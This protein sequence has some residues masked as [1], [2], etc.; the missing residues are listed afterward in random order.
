L[1][2]DLLREK[3]G[4]GNFFRYS[5]VYLFGVGCE[6]G[7][8]TQLDVWP[9]HKFVSI[10]P[11]SAKSVSE[12]V[13]DRRITLLA[14]P[15]TGARC[16]GEVVLS[17]WNAFNELVRCVFTYA[18]RS[19]KARRG[20]DALV[21]NRVVE[22]YV[23]QAIFSTPGLDAGFQA[24]LRRLRRH[25]DRD[26][27]QS[28]EAYKTVA[29]PASVRGLMGVTQVLP[30]GHQELTRR[31]TPTVIM[32][33]EVPMP[34]IEAAAAPFDLGAAATM[35]IEMP[36]PEAPVATEGLLRTAFDGAERRMGGDFA[37]RD[38]MGRISGV[39]RPSA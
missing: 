17:T 9:L 19:G 38:G 11:P 5:D 21:G 20:D 31:A 32:P 26:E 12:A 7:D 33:V 4:T 25:I 27:K 30:P 24:R 37:Q 34:P 15:E 16:R 29:G 8:F 36:Q 3:H 28:V 14:I 35:E 10:L 2:Y 6:P 39:G 13:N 18:P 22:S 1:F 23:E